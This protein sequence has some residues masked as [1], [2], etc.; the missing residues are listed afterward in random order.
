MV[1]VPGDAILYD[2]KTTFV[3]ERAVRLAMLVGRLAVPDR[4]EP[5]QS[6]AVSGSFRLPHS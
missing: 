6:V 1:T 5:R 2:W 4:F 3:S